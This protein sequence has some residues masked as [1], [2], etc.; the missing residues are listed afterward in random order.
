M[1]QPQPAGHGPVYTDENNALIIPQV[2]AGDNNT[3]NPLQLPPLTL[4]LTPTK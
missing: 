1:L 2:R 3:Y 4:T